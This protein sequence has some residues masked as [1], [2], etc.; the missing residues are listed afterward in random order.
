MDSS[1]LSLARR[2]ERV[3]RFIMN[4][5]S[6]AEVARIIADEFL[7]LQKEARPRMYNIYSKNVVATIDHVVF[8]GPATIIF[9]QDGTKTVLKCHEGD[10]F[11]AVTGFALCMLKGMLGNQGYHDLCEHWLDDVYAVDEERK[12]II[13]DAKP[14][15]A[16]VHKNRLDILEEKV[17][18]LSE[19]LDPEE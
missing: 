1:Q 8:N 6:T 9:W 19:M 11:S 7:A 14:N 4:T 15:T 13:E 16:F 3:E 17:D 10:E 2:A 18:K 12:K 5:V